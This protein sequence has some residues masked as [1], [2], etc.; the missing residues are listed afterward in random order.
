MGY[1][2]PRALFLTSNP[3]PGSKQLLMSKRLLLRRRARK[4]TGKVVQPP[5]P[6]GSFNLWPALASATDLFLPPPQPPPLD[7]RQTAHQVTNGQLIQIL[8]QRL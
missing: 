7:T 6:V 5:A 1:H 2:D 3:G 4:A 8:F